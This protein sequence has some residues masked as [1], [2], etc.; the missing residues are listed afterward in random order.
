M[1]ARELMSYPAVTCHVN[2]SLD[3]AARLMWEHDCGAIPVVDD[4]GKLKSMITDRDIC[5]AAYTQGKPLYELLVN[6]AMS[7]HVYSAG[8]E[9]PAQD[10]ERL[11]AQHQVRRIPIVDEHGA[12]I[13]V[14]SMADL[15]R[16]AV[17]PGAHV[18]Q[19][20]L[21]QTLATIDRPRNLSTHEAA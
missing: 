20:R 8:P 17:R 6:I 21:T 16:E 14:V 1:R 2:D 4:G 5:M 9:V 13:G 3:V 18:P 19:A 7:P 10:I 11:M 15:A 12:P